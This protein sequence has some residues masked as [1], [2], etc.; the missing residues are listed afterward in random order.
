MLS[1]MLSGRILADGVNIEAV[2]AMCDGLT[3]CHLKEV[4]NT[5][6]MNAIDAESLTVTDLAIIKQDHL[7]DAVTEILEN[8]P[9][10]SA[11]SAVPSAP[12]ADV[13]DRSYD[14]GSDGPPTA[15]G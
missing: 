6:V 1:E 12:D 8:R 13:I 5:A 2:A 15:I 9:D 3:P 4:V 11:V 14:T 7:T 10:P